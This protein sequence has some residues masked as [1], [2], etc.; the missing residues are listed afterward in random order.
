ME[1][2]KNLPTK[3]KLVGIREMIGLT[4]KDMAKRLEVSRV[5]YNR[6]ENNPFAFTEDEK[7][8]IQN[9]FKNHIIDCP[10]IF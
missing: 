4:Q 9:L 8:K 6:K 1:E 2:M 10:N 7:I 5:T 3:Q